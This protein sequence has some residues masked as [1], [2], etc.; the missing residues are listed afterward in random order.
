MLD[1]TMA[2]AANTTMGT[3]PADDAA[4]AEGQEGADTSR[5][6]AAGTESRVEDMSECVAQMRSQ[7]GMGM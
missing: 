2:S 3:E 6:D 5:D 7:W 1:E 4:A